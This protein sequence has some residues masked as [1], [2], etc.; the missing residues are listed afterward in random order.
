MN[1]LVQHCTATPEDS[2]FCFFGG[3]AAREAGRKGGDI[4]D[5]HDRRVRA[6]V[7]LAP[8]G[9]LFTDEALSN[10]AVPIR[11]YGAERDDLTPVQHHA[12]RLAK[13]LGPKVEYVLIKGAG[14]FSFI[15]SFP[16]ALRNAVGEA[17][18]DPRG[19]NRNAM[20]ETVN[21]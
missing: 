5:V 8:V 1:A 19:F 14:H 12:E 3:A 18:Q 20:H 10:L 6:V 16:D 2:R 4:P 21:P 7:L 9:A 13:A 15:A 17:G 11:I